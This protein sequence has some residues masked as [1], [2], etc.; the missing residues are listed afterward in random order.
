MS[1]L[2]DLTA[3]SGAIPD[4]HAA[5]VVYDGDGRIHAV[6]HC[7]ADAVEK[8]TAGNLKL[9]VMV[10]TAHHRNDYV[11]V[12]HRTVKPRPVLAG[13]DKTEIVADGKDYAT[14]RGLPIPCTVYVDGVPF[15]IEAGVMTLSSKYRATYTV[16]IDQF[17]YMPF[18][19]KLTCSSN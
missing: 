17:P 16:E 14:L 10:G 11:D 7:S 13:F 5:F 1:E 12:K 3:L 2:K 4:S 9:R 19:G 18:Q 8:Q 15:V 6:G